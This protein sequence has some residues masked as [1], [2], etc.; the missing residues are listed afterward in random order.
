MYARQRRALADLVTGLDDRQLALPVP[1]T[2][3]WSVRDVVAHLVAITADLNAQR[4][5][6]G[7]PE[8]W[9]AEQVGSRRH[10]S[11]ESLIEEWDAEAP[12]FEDGLRLFGYE[13]GS[14][15]I[16]DL[17]QHSQDIRSALE[18]GRIADEETLVVALDFYLDCFHRAVLEADAGALLVHV[19]DVEWH[20]GTGPVTAT[21]ST[22]A[23]ELLRSIG[24][25]R[26]AAQIRSLSWTGEVER[27]LPLV[28]AYGLAAD[29]LSD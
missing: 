10:R 9:T 26:S 4:F 5:G 11:I 27:L 16:G 1:A 12:T 29:D 3:L 6:P 8:V 19:G 20:L 15:F 28:S 14:H 13:L 7:D 18:L 23:F 21:L 17:V 25:R 24:G 2:P 22:T